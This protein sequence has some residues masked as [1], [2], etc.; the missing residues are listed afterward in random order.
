MTNLN[1]FL[2]DQTGP[3]ATITFNRPEKR[4]GLDPLVMLEFESLVHRAREA[5]DVKILI[6]TGTG[7]AFC[8][9]ADLT[10]ARDAV[11]DEERARIQQDMNRV[12]RIIGRVFDA[13]VHMDIIS[14]AAINGYAV[15]GGWSIAAGFDH[16]IAVEGAQFWLPE[17]EIGMPFRGLAN[18]NLTQRLGPVLA[19]EAMIL[20]RRFSAEELLQYRVINQVCAPGELEAETNR[21][22]SAYLAMPW[23]AAINTRRDIN[24][25]VY[26]PQYY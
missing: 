20:C 19:K 23:R 10:L 4:N 3:I 18:I 24:A 21:V 8:A 9:G 1:Y 25:A 15:G 11:D 6:V 16:V 2:W 7:S 22:A 13:M 17:V 12:P 14:I 5:G 26:G